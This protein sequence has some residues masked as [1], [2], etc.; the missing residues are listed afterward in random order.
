M[1]ILNSEKTKIVLKMFSIVINRTSVLIAPLIPSRSIEF[2]VCFPNPSVVG[3][4]VST[5]TLFIIASRIFIFI[6]SKFNKC[7]R[8]LPE[9][10]SG[11]KSNND[12]T[13]KLN[14]GDFDTCSAKEANVSTNKFL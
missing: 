5:Q 11:V 2:G 3:N 10:E 14:N 7:G 13:F 1:F 8:H 6:S 12:K 9:I 4:N